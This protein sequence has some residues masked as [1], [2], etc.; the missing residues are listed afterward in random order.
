MRD[1]RA[2]GV[3][4]A[5]SITLTR[6]NF[7]VAADPAFVQ[8]AI[9]EGC[10]L[11]LYLEYTP[12]QAGSDPWVLTDAQRL[13]MKERVAGFR[14]RFPAVF[15]A[16]P[17]DEEESGGCLAA[18]RGFV[19]VNAAGD[20]EPCPFAPWSDVNLTTTPMETALQSR[21]LAT[22]RRDHARFAETSGGC[23]LWKNREAV[24]AVLRDCRQSGDAPPA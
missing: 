4:F 17:W 6:A 15:I 8:G 9:A 20:L 24:Q 13:A 23:A 16:V 21:F 12:L 3:F 11:F 2:A 22:M 18:G 19:H 7:D 10:R 1:L 14:R 5:V